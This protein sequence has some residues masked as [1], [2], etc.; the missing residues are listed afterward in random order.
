MNRLKS[1]SGAD[2]VDRGSETA[3]MLNDLAIRNVLKNAPKLVTKNITEHCYYCGLY[4]GIDK[5]WCDSDCRDDWQKE[6]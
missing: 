4:V 1:I 3:D 2:D 5:R 6:Q